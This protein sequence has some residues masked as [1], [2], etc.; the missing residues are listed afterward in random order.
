MPRYNPTT[1]SDSSKQTENTQIED[2]LLSKIYNHKQ[3]SKQVL[4]TES[5]ELEKTVKIQ[6]IE[7]KPTLKLNGSQVDKKTTY[8]D[9][10]WLR[11][12][13][14][15]VENV[16]DSKRKT[17]RRHDQKVVYLKGNKGA[18]EVGFWNDARTIVCHGFLIRRRLMFR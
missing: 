7:K 2:Q 17:K 6:A 9:V 3:E 18:I 8:D 10:E 4:Q 1:E 16:I 5:Q 14:T 15:C 13:S 11:L 12:F